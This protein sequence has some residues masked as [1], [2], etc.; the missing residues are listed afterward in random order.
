[1]AEE[2]KFVGVNPELFTDLTQKD[3]ENPEWLVEI[4]GGIIPYAKGARF[5]N[6]ARGLEYRLGRRI[7]GFVGVIDHE[8]GGGGAVIVPW[9]EING[10]L[11]VGLLKQRRVTQNMYFDIWNV[12]RGY[13]DPGETHFE[14]AS[15]EFS[16][17]TGFKRPE[18]RIVLLGG[19]PVNSN[20][21]KQ[22]TSRALEGAR[23]YHFEVYTHEII[24][25]T[26]QVQQDYQDISAIETKEL[27][28]FNRAAIT[29]V[30]NM[31]ERIMGCYFL[32][33]DFAMRVGD[34]FTRG[35]VGTLK[36]ELEERIAKHPLSDNH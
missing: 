11:Y 21:A 9:V 26:V 12:P 27:Y 13:M 14:A 34:L 36:V 5:F 6:P 29:S 7:D 23:F 20:S 32:P 24:K 1:M 33:Y 28:A 10:V 17:E 30:S 8:P 16:E 35:I 3:A 25:V 2:K 4:D 31:A 19:A 22:D 15:R 18:K